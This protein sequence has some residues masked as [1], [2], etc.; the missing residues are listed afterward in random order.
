MVPAWPKEQLVASFVSL[1]A[2]L[3]PGKR[4]SCCL[5]L[6]PAPEKAR[7]RAGMSGSANLLRPIPVVAAYACTYALQ[8]DGLL[9]GGQH[10]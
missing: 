5:R 8:P 1:L 3:S 7:R 10:G 2:R 6:E 9:A 4:L